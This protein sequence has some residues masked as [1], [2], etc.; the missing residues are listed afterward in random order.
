[1]LRVI[2]SFF[3]GGND[4]YLSGT[5]YILRPVPYMPDLHSS[6]FTPHVETVGKTGYFSIV[7]G[8]WNRDR[9]SLRSPVVHDGGFLVDLYGKVTP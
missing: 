7:T 2:P 4:I 9:Y 5:F 1:M 3:T 8:T 6:A